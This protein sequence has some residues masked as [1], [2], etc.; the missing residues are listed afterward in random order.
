MEQ[1]EVEGGNELKNEMEEVE[2]IEIE[3]EIEIEIDKR[4]ELKIVEGYKENWLTHNQQQKKMKIEQ[5]NE[6]GH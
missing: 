3:I 6:G 2:S 5:R 4:D 1:N